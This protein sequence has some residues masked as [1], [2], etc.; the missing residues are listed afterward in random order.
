MSTIQT[1]DIHSLL[2]LFLVTWSWQFVFKELPTLTYGD[3]FFF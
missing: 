2:R 1:N 3:D